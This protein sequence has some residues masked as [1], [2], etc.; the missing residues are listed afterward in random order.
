[1][2]KGVP[3]NYTNNKINKNI[4][5]L[6]IYFNTF[7]LSFKDSSLEKNYVQSKH[8]K[9]KWLIRASNIFTL[10]YAILN[11]FIFFL[12]THNKADSYSIVAFYIFSILSLLLYILSCCVKSITFMSILLYLQFILFS[13]NHF[14]LCN[15]VKIINIK[16]YLEEGFL[17]CLISIFLNTDLIYLIIFSLTSLNNFI[18]SFISTL[19]KLF[20]TL[21]FFQINTYYSWKYIFYI[22]SPYLVINLLHIIISRN[23]EIKEKL[24]YIL[25]NTNIDIKPNLSLEENIEKTEKFNDILNNLNSGY[26]KLN[27]F[28]NPS[29]LNSKNFEIT[30]YNNFFNKLDFE[31]PIEDFNIKN[32]DLFNPNLSGG[33]DSFLK[34]KI[35]L[36]KILNSINEKEKFTKFIIKE[37]FTYEYKYTR[38][39]SEKSK[40]QAENHQIIECNNNLESMISFNTK[41]N[42]KLLDK[43]DTDITTSS[44]PILFLNKSKTNNLL[45]KSFTQSQMNYNSYDNSKDTDFLI[46]PKIIQYIIINNSKFSSNFS[47]LG[48]AT[49][50]YNNEILSLEILVKYTKNNSSLHEEIEFLFNDVTKI[51]LKGNHTQFLLRTSQYFH[52][53]K[54]PLICIQNEVSELKEECELLLTLLCKHNEEID[55]IQ[56]N[57]NIG[58]IEIDDEDCLNLL[59]KFDYTEK[60]SEYCQMMIGSFED[61]SKSLLNCKVNLIIH[62]FDLISLLNFIE[63]MMHFQISNT[64]KNVEFILKKEINVNNSENFAYLNSDEAKLKRVL[65]NLLSNSLKFT[66]TGSITLTVDKEILNHRNYFK[67]TITDTGVGMSKRDLEKL[68]TPFY[69]SNNNENNKNGVGLGLITVKE[70][71]EKL[72]TGIKVESMLGRGTTMSFHV[73]DKQETIQNA[74]NKIKDATCIEIDEFNILENKEDKSLGIKNINEEKL[75]ILDEVPDSSSDDTFSAEDFNVS[76]SNRMGKDFKVNFNNSVLSSELDANEKQDKIN[77]I[78]LSSNNIKVSVKKIN[79]EVTCKAPTTNTEYLHTEEL[80][81]RKLHYPIHNIDFNNLEL[82]SSVGNISNSYSFDVNSSELN[83]FNGC[84]NNLL[85]DLKSEI[86]FTR[87]FQTKNFT[88]FTRN[89]SNSTFTNN[90]VIGRGTNN[91]TNN[92]FSK[93]STPS[94]ITF[95]LYNNNYYFNNQTFGCPILFKE[96]NEN[97]KNPTSYEKIENL[98]I[99]STI[100]EKKRDNLVEN[101]DSSNLIFK[102]AVKRRSESRAN[103]SSKQIVKS[104]ISSVKLSNPRGSFSNL[105]FKKNLFSSKKIGKNLQFN[106]NDL[107]I[108]SENNFSI[109]PTQ[110]KNPLSTPKLAQRLLEKKTTKSS[111]I[112]SCKDLNKLYS[113]KELTSSLTSLNLSILII[114]DDKPIRSFCKNMFSKIEEQSRYKFEI[115]EAEDGSIGLMK[116]FQKFLYCNKGYDLIISDDS[117]TLLDG[118]SMA[119]TLFFLNE[120]KFLKLENFNIENLFSK[121][122]ISSSDPENVKSKIFEAEILRN[123]TI[124]EKPLKIEVIKIF[125]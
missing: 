2:K 63:E 43:L 14:Q 72:G 74:E 97:V 89:F 6:K 75:E 58:K 70:F 21:V 98:N 80:G 38:T 64:K 18:F 103:T 5:D 114:D 7:T 77:K 110:N 69:S 15:W 46:L 35:I 53:F 82:S 85:G 59:D 40:N 23:N 65:I 121:I 91:I 3:P 56:N 102:S 109:F 39:T 31:I 112:N 88:N 32:E 33:Y 124:C 78:K 86:S 17:V 76:I 52:D 60:M 61:L 28:S 68:F 49:L 107:L 100:C 29:V 115:E 20:L 119:R 57:H 54:N 111:F 4:S 101:A 42:K 12:K 36:D 34:E 8:S 44:T 45:K 123:I 95:S 22:L 90:E 67:F 117:M 13:L 83:N 93:S 113:D 16:D 27:I 118:S 96:Q 51:E 108:L 105:K 116:I 47:L 41:S 37:N 26:V 62:K 55:Q 1:M 81:H 24:I 11:L 99:P 10:M 104:K 9:S 122:I 30:S 48:K 71:T 94:S 84:N 73:E 106:I 125:I 50:F 120:N 79:D 87:N 19:I 92:L 66:S 25:N